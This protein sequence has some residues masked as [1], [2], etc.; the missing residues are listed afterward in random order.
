MAFQLLQVIHLQL[1]ASQSWK[2]DALSNDGLDFQ[3]NNRI[4]HLNYFFYRLNNCKYTTVD[5]VWNSIKN[6]NFLHFEITK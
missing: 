1:T 6:I 3:N 2:T 5:F 4:F